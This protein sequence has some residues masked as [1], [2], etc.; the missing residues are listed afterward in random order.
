MK[1]DKFYTD[2][3]ELE[4]QTEIAK[5]VLDINDVPGTPFTV[6]SDLENNRHFGALGNYRL[7][8]LYES[9]DV[10]SKHVRKLNW[11]NVI[12]VMTVIM[13]QYKKSEK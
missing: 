1:K 4:E 10:A 12:R 11:E 6:V 13:E 5:Q 2:N 7:T 8:E 9:K 3:K